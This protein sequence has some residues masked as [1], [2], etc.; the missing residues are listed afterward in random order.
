MGRKLIDLT[1]QQFGRLIAIEHPFKRN[2]WRCRCVCGREKFVS[3]FA[4]RS[5][6]T[7]SC[8][9][10]NSELSAARKFTHGRTGTPEY[11]S[12]HHAK[13]RCTN[14][15]DK[16][17]ADYGGRG[18]RM[19][20]EWMG[21]FEAFF[22]DVGLRPSPSHTLDRIDVNGHYE[23]GNVRWATPTQQAN[24]KSASRLITFRGETKTLAQWAAATGLTDAVIRK[25][26]DRGWSVERAMTAPPDYSKHRVHGVGWSRR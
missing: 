10:L 12:W 8:G 14:P 1:G 20:P 22:R 15:K 23:P 6:T 26:I 4:L 21:S 5:G 18:I 25:R 19:S 16:R 7:S 2:R 3:G 11:Q 24:N 17:W 13:V 9:C